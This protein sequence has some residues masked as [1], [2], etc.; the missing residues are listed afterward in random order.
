LEKAEQIVS[1]L[2]AVVPKYGLINIA[3]DGNDTDGIASG[4]NLRVLI[5]YLNREA[6]LQEHP[7]GFLEES[8]AFSDKDALVIA[9]DTF[10]PSKYMGDAAGKVDQTI[11]FD[12]HSD[13]S[14]LN[15]ELKDLGIDNLLYYSPTLFSDNEG[16]INLKFPAGMFIGFLANV[17]GID[18]PYIKLN[19]ALSLAGDKSYDAWPEFIKNCGYDIENLKEA[20]D[21]IDL[22]L[23]AGSDNIPLV[24]EFLESF[25]GNNETARAALEEKSRFN[26][27]LEPIKGARDM[28]VEDAKDPLYSFKCEDK[29]DI[30]SDEVIIYEVG[31]DSTKGFNILKSTV[32]KLQDDGYSLVF[33]EDRKGKLKISTRGQDAHLSDLMLEIYNDKKG[34]CF[35]ELGMRK[36]GGNS[37]AGAGVF[38]DGIGY[39]TTKKL[40]LEKFTR[41]ANIIS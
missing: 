36:P 13:C 21:R 19:M 25:E 33:M 2:R 1:A 27:A 24:D 3:F 26:E 23:A 30:N 11:V 32:N 37:N 14:E 18:T 5:E 39:E 16:N 29:R 6:E 38:Y 4:R 17:A 31:D 41:I 20:S 22:M 7:T 12:H 15:E 34:K 8:K 35:A 28:L 9:G 40:F 10:V